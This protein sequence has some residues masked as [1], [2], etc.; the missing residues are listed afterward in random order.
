MG[1]YKMGMVIMLPLLGGPTDL[2][3]LLYVKFLQQ[4]CVARIQYCMNVC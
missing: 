3:Q 4:Q 2:S 1:N